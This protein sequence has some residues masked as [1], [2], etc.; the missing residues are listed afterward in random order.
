VD[1]TTGDG[2]IFLARRR[3]VPAEGLYL[4][5]GTNATS[6]E[7]GLEFDKSWVKASLK[8]GQKVFSLLLRQVV[9]FVNLLH[10]V[11]DGFFGEDVLPSV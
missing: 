7:L 5:K 10:F 3:V 1:D 8:A 4:V 2:Q 9:N 11:S 6:V